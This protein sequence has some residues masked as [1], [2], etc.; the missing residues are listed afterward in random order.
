MD[1][2]DETGRLHRAFEE[3][4]YRE[5]IDGRLNSHE[6][7][8]NAINGSI[9][10]A[11]TQTTEM[12]E[13]IDKVHQAIGELVAAQATRDAVELA[14]AKQLKDAN[15]KQISGRQFWIGVAMIVVTL[16]VGVIA[17]HNIHIGAFLGV[18]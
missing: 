18:L 1:E 8:L 13:S 7:R 4:R 16:I 17:Q 9:D 2:D 10:R 15:E 3:G 12:R 6:K 14:R 5:R 11:A